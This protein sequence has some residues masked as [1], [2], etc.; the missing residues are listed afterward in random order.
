MKNILDAL[1]RISPIFY[2]FLSGLFITVSVNIYTS[3]YSPDVL[4]KYYKALLIS[5]GFCLASGIILI[6]LS[7]KLDSLQ[8]LA[9]K[10]PNGYDKGSVWQGLLNKDKQR[11]VAF[12]ISAILLALIGMLLLLIKK[13]IYNIIG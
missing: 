12:L 7:I 9:K 5:S 13:N 4:S 2:S 1:F 8:S 3:I 11:L 6:I 10:A